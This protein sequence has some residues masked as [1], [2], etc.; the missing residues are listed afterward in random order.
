MNASLGRTSSLVVLLA[1]VGWLLGGG[2]AIAQD[3]SAQPDATGASQPA[4]S[5]PAVDSPQASSPPAAGQPPQA[6]E[7]SPQPSTENVPATS[8]ASVREVRASAPGTVEAPSSSKLD[9][10]HM[11]LE[12]DPVVKGVMV[13]LAA[14]SVLAWSIFAVMML[15]I[16]VKEQRLYRALFMFDGKM[17]TDAVAIVSIYG[18]A[19]RLMNVAKE[20]I[21]RSP[22]GITEGV[23]ERARDAMHHEEVKAGRRVGAGLG[24]LASIGSTGPFIGLLGTVWGIMHSFVNIANTGTTNLSVVAPGIAEALLATAIG[25]VAAIPAVVFYNILTRR[26]SH[27]RTVLSAVSSAILRNL[28]RELDGAAGVERKVVTRIEPKQAVTA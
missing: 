15:R 13:I 2:L 26:G 12:A 28:S 21:A 20:E 4:A 16:T 5:K 9:A 3:S 10:Y 17:P 19:F 27:Y 14:G 25:L 1:A 24:V 6:A 23:I 7:T 22:I 11:F 8:P 18:D